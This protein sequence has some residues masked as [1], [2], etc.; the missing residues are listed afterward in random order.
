MGDVLVVDDDPHVRDFIGVALGAEGIPYRTAAHG[1]QALACV[2]EARP[3]VILL[4]LDMPVMD[5]R[6]FCATLDTTLGR[7][8]TTLVVMT[9]SGRVQQFQVACHAD[10]ALG[11]PFDLDDLYAAV[12]HAHQC[13]TPEYPENPA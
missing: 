4:D 3:S 13:H 9:A 7:D 2:A 10:V 11:K 12:A 6:Q 8:G 1:E 5:G